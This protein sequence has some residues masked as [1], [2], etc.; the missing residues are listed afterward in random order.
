MFPSIFS[1]YLHIWHRN[2]KWTPRS[3]GIQDRHLCGKKP[4]I[5]QINKQYDIYNILNYISI[6][7][8][9]IFVIYEISCFWSLLLKD[10]QVTDGSY[11]FHIST[12][13]FVIEAS[14]TNESRVYTMI[15]NTFSMSG[16]VV[17]LRQSSTDLFDSPLHTAEC[18]P[19]V[20]RSGKSLFSTM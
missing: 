16:N 10:E 2:S 9:W 12:L 3:H 20:H 19:S 1:G 4:L 11:I 7:L 8:I 17:T 18:I 15:S 5:W 14:S 6:T 13:P